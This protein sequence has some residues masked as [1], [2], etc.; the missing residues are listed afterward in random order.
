M[1]N[2]SSVSTSKK[3]LRVSITNSSQL[4]TFS[5]ILFLAHLRFVWK[6]N[7]SVLGLY[8]SIMLDYDFV[9][10]FQ[11]LNQFTDIHEICTHAGYPNLTHFRAGE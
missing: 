8:D 10:L 9:S 5:K 7:S 4:I 1:N 11:I 2:D 3:T 6:G